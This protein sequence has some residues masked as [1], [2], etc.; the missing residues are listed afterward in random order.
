MKDTKILKAYCD[1]TK[2]YFGIEVKKIGGEWKAVDFINMSADEASV[3][4]SELKQDRFQTSDNLLPCKKCG[5]RTISGCNCPP[6]SASCRKGMKYNFQCIYCKNLKID[7]SLPRA[8]QGHKE[9]DVI[10][11]SQGQT[12]KIHFDDNRP[13]S[14][15]IVGVGWDPV[16]FGSQMDVDS[17]VVVA[18]NAD[19][20]VIYFGNL[21]H[22]SGCVVHHGDN[23]TGVDRGGND[24][25]E[26]ITVYLDKV[27]SN[28]DRLIFVLN[29]Y[30]CVERNQ[31]MGN[32]KNMYI[33]LYDPISKKAII[34][35]KVDSNIKNDTALVIG[36]AYRQ[37]RDWRFKA[38]G[39][40]SRATS[41]Q[42][43]ADE[44]LRIR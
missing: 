8:T 28:R 31:R 26:N 1:K 40:G 2:Q 25:D 3:V 24:D 19:K 13:L 23:L 4:A 36:M 22:P 43:L 35:Y 44:C 34:E 39:K 14:K 41:I 16:S 29:I 42:S 12:V 6:S 7:Y 5:K 10:T 11:L 30:N 37:G 21:N 18:G 9:G 27:P 20:D 38:I 33:R 17:S 32:I 15:I